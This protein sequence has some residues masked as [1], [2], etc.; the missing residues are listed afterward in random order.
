MCKNVYKIYKLS[1]E[2]LV[3]GRIVEVGL[4]M[5]DP[6][7]EGVLEMRGCTDGMLGH[8]I[9]NCCVL[10]RVKFKLQGHTSKSRGTYRDIGHGLN[11]YEV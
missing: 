4:S 6:A 1:G 10:E 11:L 9:R 2:M 3:L 5:K 8:E 7:D